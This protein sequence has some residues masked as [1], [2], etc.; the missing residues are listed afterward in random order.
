MCLIGAETATALGFSSAASANFTLASTLVSFAGAGAQVAG[1]QQ[2]AAASAAQAEYQAAILRNN[3]IRAEQLAQDAIERGR[4]EEAEQRRTTRRLISAQEAG[5]AGKG[6]QVNVGTPLEV[7]E[8][9]ARLGELDALTIRNNAAREAAGFRA[10]GADFAGEATLLRAGAR[11][12][13]RAQ[14]LRTAGTLLTT[15]GSLVQRF[16]GRVIG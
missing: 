8:E 16:G 11:Q 6:V 9:T 5:F 1:Q 13:R 10:Q 4:V 15:T 12:T 14:P 3:Q 2:Q 7:R